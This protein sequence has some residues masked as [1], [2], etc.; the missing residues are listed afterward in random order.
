MCKWEK[1]ETVV[2]IKREKD[3][4]RERERQRQREYTTYNIHRPVEE[5]TIT[6]GSTKTQLALIREKGKS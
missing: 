2:K 3:R 5:S 4:E 6:R 1:S